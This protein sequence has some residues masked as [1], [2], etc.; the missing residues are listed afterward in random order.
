M[1][2]L[3]GLELGIWCEL[4]AVLCISTSVAVAL[5]AFISRRMR[6]AVWERAVWQACTLTLLALVALELTGLGAATVRLFVAS[7]SGFR[8][9][10]VIADTVFTG[11]LEGDDGIATQLQLTAA[12]ST[13][14]A[15]AHTWWPAIV[16][17]IG[18]L[19]LLVRMAWGRALL[20]VFWWRCKPLCDV[21]IRSRVQSIANRLGLR[22]AIQTLTSNSL[23][24]PAVFHWL[25][26]VLALPSRFSDDYSA[27]QQEAVLAHE[28]AH[29]ARRDPAWQSV[30]ML[31][32]AL[33]WWQPLS[34]WSSRRLRAAS[35]S[36]AD[37]ACLM[38]ADGPRQ[39]AASLVSLAQ[40]LTDPHVATG[41]SMQGTGLKS[42]LARRVE[43]LLS[44]PVGDRKAPSKLRLAL[45]HG[46]LPICFSVL[47]ILCTAWAPS[48]RS[49]AQGETTVNVLT[50]A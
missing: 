31:T 41:T 44:L 20:A 38:L 6:S 2:I 13:L 39:L 49:F 7:W 30:A 46:A 27:A 47:C 5:A 45:A 50:S 19:A 18:S 42:D 37:E 3:L 4:L 11:L 33:L 40:R 22:R 29:L 21:T 17:G 23:R 26:P 15:P 25:F 34:W 14:A 36:A 24:S 35:E 1:P 9:E 43:R 10:R 16:W 28:L 32:C 12:T 8:S 48:R